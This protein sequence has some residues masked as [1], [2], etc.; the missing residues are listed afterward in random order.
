MFLELFRRLAWFRWLFLATA[1]GLAGCSYFGT[2]EEP[3][4]EHADWTAEQL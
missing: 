2:K 3:V 4:D 1:L